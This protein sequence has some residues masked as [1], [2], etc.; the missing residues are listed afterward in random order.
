MLVRFF[1]RGKGGGSGP[2]NYLM[3]KN[4]D[5]EHAQVLRGNLEQTVENINGLNFAR[6]Y[7][8]GCLSFAE[9]DIPDHHKQ[10]LM[11]QFE[12]MIFN[13]LER[14]QYD[15][16]WV[17]HQDK[18]RLELN[19][20]IPNVDLQSGKRYQ[21]YFHQSEN[22]MMNAW[23]QVVNDSFGLKDPHDPLN[24]AVLTRSRDCPRDAEQAKQT[25]TNSLLRMAEQGLVN[26]RADVYQALVQNGFEVARE[27]SKSISIKSPTGG[28]NIRLQGALYERAFKNGSGLREELERASRAY[29]AEREQRLQRSKQVYQFGSGKKRERNAKR[30]GRVERAS[31]EQVQEN[32]ND[33][34]AGRAHSRDIWGNVPSKANK[35]AR[36]KN[37]QGN[38]RG[39]TGDLSAYTNGQRHDLLPTRVK[40]HDRIRATIA[41]ITQAATSRLR[42]AVQ[43]TTRVF[44]QLSERYKA[45]ATKTHHRA[46]ERVREGENM[47][48]M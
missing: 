17:Q 21:P 41:A 28:R 10:N 4:R 35:L 31:L 44:E 7:T 34:T 1:N 30:Y 11:D 48:R 42:G 15:I 32:A 40:D 22:K 18:G 16:T 20:L 46:A 13:G 45:E 24:K 36:A 3:G 6:N 39:N 47:P 43:R 23:Q 5:R 29:Q 33:V 27:T 8:S 38:N 2:A 12:A 9:K 14:D 37:D 19:F 26:N 25:I